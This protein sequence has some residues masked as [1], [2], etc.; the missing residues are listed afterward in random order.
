[1]ILRVLGIVL[2]LAAAWGL[3]AGYD[4]LRVFRGTLFWDYR[5]IIFAVGAFL[6]L[7]V[8]EALFSWLKGKFGAGPD[9]D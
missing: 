9:D 5:Y 6:A 2:A 3:W 7:S 1:M 4:Q 8:L